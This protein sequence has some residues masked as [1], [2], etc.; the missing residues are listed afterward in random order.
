MAIGFSRG[1]LIPNPDL[2]QILFLQYTSEHVPAPVSGELMFMMDIVYFDIESFSSGLWVGRVRNV[3][4]LVYHRLAVWWAGKAGGAVCR[5]ARSLGPT[6]LRPPH[7]RPLRLWNSL[8]CLNPFLYAHRSVVRLAGLACCSI[9]IT[10]SRL[11][12]AGMLQLL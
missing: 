8:Q 6:P 2:I 5:Y 1:I 12:T 10:L 7:H 9:I 4:C 3:A 11:L